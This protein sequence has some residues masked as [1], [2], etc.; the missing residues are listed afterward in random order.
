MRWSPI[1]VC[2]DHR[3]AEPMVA[4]YCLMRQSV[5]RRSV[6]S[7]EALDRTQDRGPASSKAADV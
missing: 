4:L 5:V 3:F 7:R 6:P 1:F 2:R